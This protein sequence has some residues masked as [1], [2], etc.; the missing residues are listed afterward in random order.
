[1]RK[2][3]DIAAELAQIQRELAQSIVHCHAIPMTIGHPEM[4][5]AFYHVECCRSR[6]HRLQVALG[7]ESIESPPAA[8]H[9]RKA[10]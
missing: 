9:H 7:N 3:L 1:M 4:T 6:L 2:P 5:L 8:P 10:A